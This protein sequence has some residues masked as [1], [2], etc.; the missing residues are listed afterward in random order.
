MRE[1]Q[2]T[3]YNMLKA[4]YRNNHIPTHSELIERVKSFASLLPKLEINEKE[5]DEIVEN[6]ET[7]VGV[8]AFD[9]E[10]LVSPN[11]STTWFLRK[12]AEPNRKHLFWERYRDYLCY[13]ED[14]DENTIEVLKRSTEEILGLCANPTA[15]V[16]EVK[17]RK[18]LVVGDVQSG[19]TANYMALINMACDYDYKLIIVLAGLTDS[20]R[21]QTQERVDKGFIGAVS[22]TIGSGDADNNIIY[23]GVGVA[24]KERYAVTLTNLD[25]DFKK[26]SLTAIN[27][28]SGDYN[29]PVV[30]VVKKNK[31]T[32]ENVIKWLKPQS[33][34]VTDHIL[35]IDDEADNASINTKKGDEDPS[36]INALIRDLYNNF[37]KASYVGYTATPFA[38]IFIN[39]DDDESYRDLFPTDFITLLN[40]PT[41]YFGAEKVFGAERTGKTKHIRIVNEHEEYFLPVE[42]KKDDKFIELSD[43]LKESI[44][45]FFINNVIRTRRGKPYAHRSMMINISRFNKMQKEIKR[46]VSEYVEMLKNIISQTSFMPKDKFLR[47]SEMLKMYNLYTTSNYYDQIREDFSWEDIQEHLGYE[48]EK[49]KVL[50]LNRLKDEEK[51]DY[52][53]YKDEGARFIVVGGFV[54][55]RGL[56][57]EGLMISY[58]S[59]NGSAYDSLLQMCRWFGYRPKY[60]DLCRIYMS[61]INVDA[62]GAV[63]EA[64]ED[65]KQQFRIMKT[66]NKTPD[67][68]GLMVK[69]SP[70]VLNTLL[71]TSRNKS[72]TAADKDIILNYS[73]QVVDTSK[74]YFDP[75]INA[76]NLKILKTELEEK[77]GNIEMVG[78]R[79][80]Y[81]MV[82]KETIISILSAYAIPDAN[83]TFDPISICEFLK[84][85]NKLQHW[86]V[87][88]AKGFFDP[89]LPLFEFGGEK[90]PCVKR[91][92][93]YRDGEQFVRI[94]GNNNRLIDPGILDSN[95]DRDTIKE[96]KERVGLGKTPQAEDY[97]KERKFPILIIY[98]I[99]LKIEKNEE[100]KV[101]IKTELHGNYLMGLGIG[102]PYNGEGILIRY[103][104][105]VR[106]L[107]ELQREREVLEEDVE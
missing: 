42:H 62:F 46:K 26:E 15:Q 13:D 86:D 25:K 27:N 2:K 8:R 98:P 24:Q 92:F 82:D 49:M 39:P 5:I 69:R 48:A 37:P 53:K 51:L 102:F 14:F 66:N 56:T 33:E 43:S 7:N 67:D 50:L 88:I 11:E 94:S 87:V 63:I 74:I 10:T 52:S 80:M 91:N 16:G 31:S 89:T 81:R 90:I 12:K 104:L 58:Y 78:N 45:S 106:R 18:G 6:Y 38:N 29:K 93:E 72:R 70:D 30:L 34:G 22:N 95:M 96:I 75:E 20:L 44:L 101:K 83:K 32:L 99:D 28:T 73:K 40:T 85:S 76:K 55:S 105:N 19:K 71:I 60:E 57:L 84:T 4:L 61:Q 79:H 100:D 68:F 3:I 17:K 23:V 65:L 47:N 59:R 77:Y 64:T 97:L 41:S 21:R 54:L 107:Q 35:I 9:P 36:I 1:E 103:K